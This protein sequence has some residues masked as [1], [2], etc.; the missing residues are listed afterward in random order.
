MKSPLPHSPSSACKQTLSSK[1][2]GLATRGGKGGRKD[3]RLTRVGHWR[4]RLMPHPRAPSCL[5]SRLLGY[6]T[7]GNIEPSSHYLGY[8]SPAC[9]ESIYTESVASVA[10][11]PMGRYRDFVWTLDDVYFGVP[12]VRGEQNTNKQGR[13]GL[14]VRFVDDGFLGL[15]RLNKPRT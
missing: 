7:I 12:Y 14:G 9:H 3:L 10:A 11:W 8:W 1:T 13:S 6:V 5:N 15:L 2:R 4:Y